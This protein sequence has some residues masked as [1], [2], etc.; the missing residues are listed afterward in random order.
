MARAV[1][2][3]SGSSKG[4]DT[5]SK[6]RQRRQPLI[7]AGP[8]SDKYIKTA[9][10]GGT[11]RTYQE[12][13]V[14]QIQ[15]SK[16]Q[17]RIDVT[18]DLDT[19]IE[20]IKEKGQQIPIIVRI[21]TGGDHP[22][23]IVVGRRRLAAIKSLGQATIKAFVTKMDEKEAFVAQGIENNER[24]ETSFIERARAA[25][26]A[27]EAGF[28][29]AEIGE[30]L[31]VSRSMITKLVGV[32]RNLGEELVLAI[33]PA[34]SVGRRKWETLI[35]LINNSGLEQEEIIEMIDRS[36]SSDERFASLEDH[37]RMG[38]KQPKPSRKQPVSSSKLVFLD[39][40]MST[41]RKPRQ[42]LVKL[43]HTL[44]DTI[45]DMLEE[46]VQE[47]VDTWKKGDRKI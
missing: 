20:S 21:I 7:K 34:H 36:L 1:F 8:A 6:P 44:P 31:S 10:Q 12:I 45:L 41:T 19:L 2:D 4:D 39:G 24:L 25:Y 47:V 35:Q 16:I 11:D 46:H 17:D 22:Y 27:T 30:F 15:N 29:H 33:G 18:D 42:L 28:E 38:L 14:D 9:A 43:D 40:A 26:Q 5:P 13:S 32:Y 3:T 23:E 37:L